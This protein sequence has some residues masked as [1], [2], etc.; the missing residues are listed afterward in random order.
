LSRFLHSSYT[1][2]VGASGTGYTLQISPSTLILEVL[3]EAS[4]LQFRQI[5]FSV[6]YRRALVQCLLIMRTPEAPPSQLAWLP[7]S[8]LGGSTSLGTTFLPRRIHLPHVAFCPTDP[9]TCRPLP[10]IP[11]LAWASKLGVVNVVDDDGVETPEE[12]LQHRMAA[13]V[14]CSGRDQHGPPPWCTRIR[15]GHRLCLLNQSASQERRGGPLTRV[16]ADL[17]RWIPSHRS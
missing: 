13:N 4:T 1:T 8:H 3:E 5:I 11:S 9:P 2:H 12:E 17:P 7:G 14:P 10:P 16:H 6:S 15:I